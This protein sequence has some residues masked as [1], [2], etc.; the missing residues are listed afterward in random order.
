MTELENYIGKNEGFKDRMYKCTAGKWTLGWGFNIED[1]PIPQEVADFW[2]KH[3]VQKCQ[4]ELDH[5]LTFY[6][7]LPENVK[8]VLVDMCYNLGITRLL[9]FTN[10]LTAIQHSDYKTAGE[11]LMNSA[12]AGQVPNRAYRN[13]QLL[14]GTL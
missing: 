6:I 14:T 13:K 11:E 12:Y 2:L 7:L 1:E 4:Y 10:M 8:T 5:F 9:K 3:K